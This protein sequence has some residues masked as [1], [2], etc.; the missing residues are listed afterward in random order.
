MQTSLTISEL[1]EYLIKQLNVFFPD[2]SVF[3][4]EKLG[5]AVEIA[6]LR[7]EMCFRHILI[8]GYRGENGAMFSH[9]H[10]DQYGTFL[11]F[12]SN[13]LYKSYDMDAKIIC[14]KLLNLNRMLNGF[15]LS[16]KCPMPEVFVLAHPVGSVIGNALYS[17][18]LYISQNVTINTHTDSYGNLD[19]KIGKGCFL[20]AGAKVIGNQEIG[21]RVSIGVDTVIYNQRIS[22]D[23]VCYLNNAG[24]IVVRPRKAKECMAAQIF[25]LDLN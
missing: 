25:D 12:V 17:N 10:M 13:T 5:T 15:F 22:N 4:K 3:D 1:C 20:G 2:E 8:P 7:C 9:L 6:L 14:D 24:N 16:Y 11:Y 23:S 19:L 21:D 18:G